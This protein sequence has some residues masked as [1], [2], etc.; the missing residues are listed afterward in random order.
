MQY[1]DQHLHTDSSEDSIAAMKDMAAA[2]STA[3]LDAI[4][5][6]DHCDLIYFNRAG[7]PDPNC[8]EYWSRSVREYNEMGKFPGLKVRIGMEL[9]AINQDPENA[10]RCYET[11]GLDFTLGS[12]HSMRDQVDFCLI[13][14]RDYDECRNMVAQ[15][16][17]EN[18]E[19]A[20]LGYFD[21]LAHVGYTIRYMMPYGIEIDYTQFEDMLKEL[22]S[23]LI[24]SGKGL[25]LNTSGLRQGAGT[26]FPTKYMIELYRQ[27]GGEIVT[28]G[29]DAHSPGDVG[30]CFEQ[31]TELLVGVGFR[32]MAVY[33]KHKP[34]FVKIR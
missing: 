23:I 21:S 27:C 9:G 29:S 19:T 31:A 8:Y 33:E 14:Y 26:M 3:G 34:S 2:A 13:K 11:E 1:I 32:Y 30:S 17:D 25:E 5:F 10:R 12:V 24:H 28:V 7:V 6:T 18:I 16:L 4:C 22:Y 20:K 15:Y